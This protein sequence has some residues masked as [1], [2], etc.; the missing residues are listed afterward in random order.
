MVL[1][2]ITARNILSCP[3]PLETR[4]PQE[5]NLVTSCYSRSGTTL[6]GL[7]LNA[8]AFGKIG[9]LLLIASIIAYVAG[10]IMLILSV[11]GLWH[12]R[13]A[14]PQQELFGGSGR[15]SGSP[16]TAS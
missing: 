14:A 4:Q 16:A 3:V 1:P 2:L 11:L 8:Y 7:L 6:R 12:S 13:H 15:P 9:Q 5:I 10:G